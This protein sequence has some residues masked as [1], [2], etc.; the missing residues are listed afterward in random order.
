MLNLIY[1]V[2]SPTISQE[3]GVDNTN[4]PQ[5]FEFYKLFDNKHPGVDFEVPV[6]SPVISSYPGIV[7]RREFHEGMGNVVGAR[8]GNIVILYAHLSE[9]GVELGQVIGQGDQ[10]GLSGDTGEALTE[11]HL[12]FELRNISKKSLKYM[13][14]KPE[15]NKPIENLTEEF[16]YTTNNNN[17]G[18]TLG[19]LSLKFFGTHDYWDV[20]RQRNNLN[21]EKDELILDGLKL[22][23]PNY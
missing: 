18:K 2:Q 5:R 6:G 15:F 22:V 3:F 20:L 21:A 12:H 8:N 7:V 1:P 4:H 17:T 13:V 11:P 19:A 9:F 14:F 10:I 16:V 23:I